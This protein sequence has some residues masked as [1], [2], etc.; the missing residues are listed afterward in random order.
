MKMA[1]KQHSG[2]CVGDL[3]NSLGSLAPR[4]PS[5]NVSSKSL[6]RSSA[7]SAAYNSSRRASSSS[8]VSANDVGT[9]YVAQQLEQKLRK[10][11]A[12]LT[13]FHG[14]MRS[15]ARGHRLD[16]ANTG[17][18]DI[19]I[20]VTYHNRSSRAL[21]SGVDVSEPGNAT[22]DL[23]DLCSSFIEPQIAKAPLFEG[24]S[25]K[26]REFGSVLMTW[27]QAYRHC[28]ESAPEAEQP[29]INELREIEEPRVKRS[30]RVS[31]TTPDETD[32]WGSD[33]LAQQALSAS[34]KRG[35]DKNVEAMGLS[36]LEEPVRRSSTRKNHTGKTAT[37]DSLVQPQKS[38]RSPTR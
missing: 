28:V 13:S 29:A 34:T 18:D 22:K 11:E 5:A 36:V 19:G 17:D 4:Q 37:R 15:H 3:D 7:G 10:N 38:T 6:R 8:Q 27:Q 20:L 23:R 30:S 25:D 14:D 2:G 24:K 1:S 16:M 26:Y 31:I 12:E 33:V 35:I 32:V 21:H 9:R